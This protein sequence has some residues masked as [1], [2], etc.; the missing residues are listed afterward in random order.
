MFGLLVSLSN[1]TAWGQVKHTM[2]NCQK[3]HCTKWHQTSYI[4]AETNEKVVVFLKE[5]GK[6]CSTNKNCKTITVD[7]YCKYKSRTY[8]YYSNGQLHLKEI[9]KGQ[10][11]GWGGGSRVTKISYDTKGKMTSK[12]RFLRVV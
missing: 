4:D 3:C 1:Y 2:D 10:H 11:S 5:K 9:E 8:H 6:G 7:G 12:Q